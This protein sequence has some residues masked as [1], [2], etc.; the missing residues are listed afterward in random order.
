V[1]VS[2]IHH[3]RGTSDCE[4]DLFSGP[5]L[6]EQLDTVPLVDRKING[7]V[8]LPISEKYKD[9]GTVVV[10]KLESGRMKKGD[11][12]LMMPNKV[13]TAL[14]RLGSVLHTVLAGRF[15]LKSAQST[16]RLRTK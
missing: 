4:L 2:H 10:G 16:V 15:S 5:S 8:M 13:R 6:L 3:L 1:D 14:L 12:L 9:L 11:S 7:P